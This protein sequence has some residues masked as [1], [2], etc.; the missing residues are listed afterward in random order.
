MSAREPAKQ[1]VESVEKEI[2]K[3]IFTDEEI[4][5]RLLHFLSDLEI[6]IEQA[7]ERQKKYGDDICRG[8]LLE[9]NCCR[10]FFIFSNNRYK[11]YSIKLPDRIF[12]DICLSRPVDCY[13]LF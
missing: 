13:V 5:R 3:F 6:I 2:R 11:I 7:R 1:A 9:C 8:C 4:E 12:S 10:I